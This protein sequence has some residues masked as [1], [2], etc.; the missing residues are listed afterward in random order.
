MEEEAYWHGTIFYI[1]HKIPKTIVYD[2][3]SIR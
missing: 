2:F 1:H 3:C